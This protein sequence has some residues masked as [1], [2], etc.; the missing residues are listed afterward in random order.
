MKRLSIFILTALLL[1]SCTERELQL[2]ESNISEI[3]E[4]FDVS[5]IYIFYD[6]N[7][8]QADFNRNN[9][10][11]TTNWLV[12]IDKR[13]KMGEVLHHLIYLQEK[14]RGDGFHKNELARN[15]FS[16]SNT[17]IMDLSF[18]DFTEITYHDE[19]IAD[20]LK[21]SSEA[22]SGLNQVFITF[23]AV[24]KIIIGRQSEMIETNIGK[25]GQI[26]MGLSAKNDTINLVFL[27]FSSE[28]TFQDYISIKSALYGKEG[29]KLI[30]ARDEFIYK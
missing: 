14:R 24:D 6:E 8:G 27:N 25:L 17:E 3:T 29:S 7:T 21:K 11:G 26:L 12:N 10:I 18:L 23:E 9:M 5:P 16:C 2:P 20:F 30:M 13:L 4:V 22:S 19:A 28:L 15:Y 1:I